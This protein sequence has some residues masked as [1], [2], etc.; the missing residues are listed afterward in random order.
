MPSC[1]SPIQLNQQTVPAKLPLKILA[2]AHLSF[3]RGREIENFVKKLHLF[4]PSKRCAAD[5]RSWHDTS[6]VLDSSIVILSGSLPAG[7]QRTGLV[8]HAYRALAIYGPTLV[9]PGRGYGA[10]NMLHKTNPALVV[11]VPCRSYMVQ[12]R[13]FTATN[14]DS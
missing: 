10:T 11:L 14:G 3:N 8:D 13:R 1:P 5:T 6:N 4:F 2:R 7:R 9:P 12:I